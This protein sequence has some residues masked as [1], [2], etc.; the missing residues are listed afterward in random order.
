MQRSGGG[1]LAGLVSAVENIFAVIKGGELPVYSEY[2]T[3]P[4]TRH[5]DIY[6]VVGIGKITLENCFAGKGGRCYAESCILRIRLLG[7]NGSSPEELYSILDCQLLD[8]L[9][10]SGIRIKKAEIS[11]PVPDN[12]L[13]KLVLECTAEISGR[14]EEC[15]EPQS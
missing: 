1:S 4:V 6:A 12:A 10:S 7:K 14:T 9:M 3:I 2:E 11:A 5:E 8:R 13:K 15:Y